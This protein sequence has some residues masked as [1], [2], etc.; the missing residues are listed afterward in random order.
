MKS[1]SVVVAGWTCCLCALG[2]VLCGIGSCNKMLNEKL[3]RDYQA[4]PVYENFITITSMQG[5]SVTYSI[6]SREDLYSYRSSG[7]TVIYVHRPK[8]QNVVVP[9]GWAYKIETFKLETE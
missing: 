9:V 2:L 3:E 7:V 8:K 5:A 4:L 1:K 6:I